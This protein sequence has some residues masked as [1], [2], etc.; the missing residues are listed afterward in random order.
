MATPYLTADDIAERLNL[1]RSQV[2]K[3]MRQ[4]KALV[5]GRTLRVHPMAFEAAARPY[6]G[7]HDMADP[8][9]FLR[10]RTWWPGS[11]ANDARPAARTRRRPGC[12]RDLERRAADPNTKPR[13][14]P[15][16]LTP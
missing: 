2:Y 15:R 14:K 16:S 12:A 11:S 1:S 3:P 10:G 6:Q 5:V 9:L 4:M 7:S 8:K 13:T